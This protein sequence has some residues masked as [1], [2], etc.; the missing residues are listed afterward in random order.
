[1]RAGTA[2]AAVAVFHDGDAYWL[3]DGFHRVRAARHAELAT[4]AA[5]V[6]QGTR[7][8]CGAAD[9]VGAQCRARR[10]GGTNAD[11][12]R[13]AGTL[14]RDPE[15]A[16]VERPGD[17][18]PLRGIGSLCQLCSRRA[19]CERCADADRRTVERAGVVYTQER[20]IGASPLKRDV[21]LVANQPIPRPTGTDEPAPAPVRG[22]GR[23]AGDRFKDRLGAVARA[24]DDLESAAPH[25]NRRAVAAGRGRG[26]ERAWGAPCASR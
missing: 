26:A 11:K 9:S 17:R 20:R 4:I 14:L 22:N 15:W 7:Q 5:E 21:H 19:I 6:R 18:P 2:S 12:H 13:A 1:M 3:A 8:G 10:S 25:R 16:G 24:I 23:H